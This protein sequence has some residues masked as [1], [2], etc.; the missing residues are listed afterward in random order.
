MREMSRFA[1]NRNVVL[2]ST[3][4]VNDFVIRKYRKLSDD[5]SH[6]GYDVVLLLNAEDGDEWDIPDD[7]LCFTTDSDSINELEYEPIEE[8]LLPGS[9]HFSILRFFT[10]LPSYSFYWF[11]EYDVEFTGSWLTLMND[12]DENLADYDFLSCHVERFNEKSNGHW[13]WWY[14]SN[15]LDYSLK[16]SLKGFNPI[17]RYSKAALSYLNICQK[18]GCCAHSEVLIT[19]CLYHGGYSIGDFGGVGEFV[20]SGYE[21]KFY[22]PNLSV[23][24][25]GTMRYRPVYLREEIYRTGLHDKLFHPIKG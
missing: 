12:S 23:T 15:G 16:D 13:T 20:P 9:C 17:C 3:H 7:I 4:M 11:V 19:T 1:C 6:D 10:D 5:L 25:D 24:N 21:N 22:V 14:R 18:Q 2:L 8:T